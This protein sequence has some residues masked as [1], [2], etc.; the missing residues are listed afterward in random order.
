MKYSAKFLFLT[1]K[2][3]KK[4]KIGTNRALY[5]VAG[6]IRTTERRAI[7]VRPGAGRAPSPPH[8]HTQGGLRVIEFAV[9]GNRAVIG[10]K[11]FP[12]SN[13]WNSPVPHIHEFGGQYV[14]RKGALARYPQRSY[15]GATLKRLMDKGKIT[16]EFSVTIAEVL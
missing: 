8:A 11:K 7:R 16:K 5:R 13:F 10:P 3:A 12:G 15:A 6:L 1:N 14:S 2:L 9:T 4:A